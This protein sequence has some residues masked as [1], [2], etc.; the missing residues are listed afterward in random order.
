M[1][2]GPPYGWLEVPCGAG[3]RLAARAAGSA[4]ATL[5]VLVF[6]RA[7]AHAIVTR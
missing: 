3:S 1:F 5:D 4:G 7:A 2:L 6:P